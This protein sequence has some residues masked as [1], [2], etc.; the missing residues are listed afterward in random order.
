MPD[1]CYIETSIPSFYHDTR[2]NIRAQAMRKWTRQWW[3]MPGKNA[4]LLTGLPVA[5]ELSRAPDP[6]REKCMRLISG[7]PVL[8]YDDIADEIVAAYIRHRLMPD[9]DMGDAAHLALASFHKC[10]FLVTWNCRNI[11]NA[12]KFDHIRR[13]NGMLG[14]FTPKLVTPLQLLEGDYDEQEC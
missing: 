2:N 9:E 14:L 12:N 4:V 13:V 10:D 11:A 6:K 3:H 1:T 5:A 7:L 8:D